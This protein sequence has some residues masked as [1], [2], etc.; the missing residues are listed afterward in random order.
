MRE[1]TTPRRARVVA[2]TI[3]AAALAVASIGWMHTAGGRALLGRLGVPCPV[4]TV[5][6]RQVLAVRD[7]AI[8]RTRGEAL[9]PERPALGLQLDRS[10]EPQVARRMSSARAHCDAIVRGYRYLRCR[11]VA[12]DALGV[13]GPPVSEIWFSFDPGGHLVAV[14]LYRRGMDES[15]ARQSWRGA[16]DGLQQAL[17]RPTATTGDPSLAQLLASP[18]G[19]ARIQ[20]AYADYVATVT[21]SRLPYGGL[22][23]RELYMS[24]V[25]PRR[26]APA[27]AQGA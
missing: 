14:N 5:D 13:E 3:A 1:L 11:G 19:V 15:Q 2:G 21:A 16:V 23:V 22:A 8:A 17:G 10:T 24:A 9:A 6:A 26:L 7:D 25:T 20:Y 18:L 27:P 4:N 12:A